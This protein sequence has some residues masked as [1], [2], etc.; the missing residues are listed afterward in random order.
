MRP[1]PTTPTILPDSSTPVYF[2]RFHSPALSAAEAEAV[3][4]ATASS[5]AT[6]CSAADTM[7][8]VGALTTMTPRAVAAGT[9]TLSSPT[10]P[11]ATTLRLGPA[12]M[13]PAPTLGGLAQVTG[14]A[15]RRA[16]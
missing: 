14:S 13:A 3:L 9:S 12:A 6:A 5:S 11:R 4:R 15:A 1:R 7:L 8:D 16:A 10:P 2:D